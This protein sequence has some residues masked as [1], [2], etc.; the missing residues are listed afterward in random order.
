ML[1]DRQAAAARRAWSIAMEAETRKKKILIVDD[2][3]TVL[4]MEEML[5]RRRYE[6]LKATG[7]AQALRIVADEHPDLI[8]LDIVMPNMD[9]I[10]ACRL[11]RAI[12]PAKSIPIIMV[13]T[14]G[15]Q[16]VIDAAYASGATDYVTKPIDQKELLRKIEHHLGA[17]A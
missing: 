12:G 15:E 8:L 16:R 6:V 17:G 2:S 13:T 1:G 7:G 4:I 3:S 14:R 5:L 10:E 11:L 9:G